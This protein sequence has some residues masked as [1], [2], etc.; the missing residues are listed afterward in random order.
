MKQELVRINSADK[1]EM[2]GM[3]Y[4]PEEKS[5]K[6]VIHVHGLCGNFYENR[7]IDILAKNYTSKKIS[8]LTFNN[9]GTNYISEFLKGDEFEIIGGCNEKFIDCLLDIE[10]A[11]KYVKGKGYNDIILEGHSYGS[12][13]YTHLDVYKR[14]LSMFDKVGYSIAMDNAN[15]KIKERA[16]E[17]TL[18][19]EDDGVAVFLEKLLN[20]RGE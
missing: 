3:L 4:E 2:V 19:N 18:S 5:N 17:V 20:V 16:S 9:R 12:V 10:G 14:Q 8:L 13:S 1:I 15:P 6:I 7:F 11:I